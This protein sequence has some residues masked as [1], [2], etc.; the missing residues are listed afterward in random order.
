MR[1]FSLTQACAVNVP[2]A[3]D[4]GASVHERNRKASGSSQ[5]DEL[6][7]WSGDHLVF[8][9][10]DGVEVVLPAMPGLRRGP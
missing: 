2:S 4:M 5:E 10:G 8:L 3:P 6:Y 9:C 1:F 7:K